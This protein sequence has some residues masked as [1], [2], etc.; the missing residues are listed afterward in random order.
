MFNGSFV[1]K[2]IIY[3]D[4]SSTTFH[5]NNGLKY[6][7]IGVFFG[8]DSEYNISKSYKGS[9]V[10]NQRMELQACINGI[11][12]CIEITEKKQL[13]ELTI[14]TDSM[15]TINCITKWANK[16]IL[17]GWKRK[18]GTQ[19]KEIKN[20]DLIKE[21]YKL[22]KLYPIK[23]IHRKAHQSEPS[24]ENKIVWETW[25]GNKIADK[26]AGDAMHQLKT[27]SL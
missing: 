1:K 4:G 14:Y 16:W 20:L 2:I 22:S 3:T 23:Y 15:Y 21:L 17:W 5:D 10:T 25:Y 18:V 9:N 13:W 7:G 26:L 6:G 11:Q 8:N 19:Y 27:S 24:K 12:K